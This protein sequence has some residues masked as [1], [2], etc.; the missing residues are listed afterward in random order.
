MRKLLMSLSRAVLGSM[1]AL[2]LAVV[3]TTARADALAYDFTKSDQ[4]GIIDLTTGVFSEIGNTG[5]LL[6][7]LGVAPN[8]NIYGGGINGSELYEV[9]KATGALTAIG[10][11]SFTYAGFGSTTTG[12]YALSRAGNLYSVNQNTGAGTLIGATH[13]N[14]AIIG[15]DTYGM[16]T[17]SNVLY[18]TGAGDLYTLNTA[19]GAAT[20]VGP[21]ASATFGADV[22]ENGTLYGGSNSPLAVY[23]LN[24]ATGAGTLDASVSGG[25]DRFWGLTPIASVPEPAS[26]TLMLVGLGVL[27][28]SLRRSRR[29]LVSSEP[30]PA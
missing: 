26:W 6:S 2:T 11:G 18:F 10:S 23:T 16:S 14:G 1:A 20:L 17:G 9:S 13:L 4:F 22:Y 29:K 19:T 27:G 3:S 5:T 15:N 7:G 24:P 25:A 30:R 21:T 12:L 8:G 28:A